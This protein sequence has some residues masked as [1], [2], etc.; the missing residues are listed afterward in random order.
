[1]PKTRKPKAAAAAAP[2]NDD[3]YQSTDEL[4]DHLKARYEA[5]LEDFDMQ[6]DK[7]IEELTNRMIAEG[8][9][10]YNDTMVGMMKLSSSK[11]K[12]KWEDQ[13]QFLELPSAAAASG[14]NVALE[15]AKK[16][17]QAQEEIK[18]LKEKIANDVQTAMKEDKAA[19]ST[20]KKRQAPR[21]LADES[22][23]EG[24]STVRKSSRTRK[25]K[26]PF[27]PGKAGQMDES[28]LTSTANTT[29]TR[30]RRVLQ[31][32]GNIS[33]VAPPTSLPFITPKVD[34]RTPM[35]VSVMRISKPN[36][37]LFS[38]NGSP[39]IGGA[40]VTTSKR[41]GGK[42]RKAAPAPDAIVAI[43]GNKELQLNLDDN[44]L[45]EFQLDADAAAKVEAVRNQLDRLLK[46]RKQ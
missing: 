44:V 21:G 34:L 13:L 15:T 41:G 5:L 45:P 22:A 30:G 17:E 25:S 10:F 42:G 31:T 1:M 20:V 9:K 7:K 32:P 35:P 38:M 3:V 33:I 6:V 4:P 2:V 36:E 43:G 24:P 29:R 26:M 39:V 16:A 18:Q 12:E 8:E 46:N 28:V 37:T 19:K 27:T 14:K 40:G 11:R 23:M